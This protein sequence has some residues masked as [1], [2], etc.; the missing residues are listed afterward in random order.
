MERIVHTWPA[1]LEPLIAALARRPDRPDCWFSDVDVSEDEL[2]ALN[3][4]EA[5]SRHG[6]VCF[7]LPGAEHLAQG[8]MNTLLGLGAPVERS[9]SARVRL[10]FHDVASEK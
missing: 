5:S 9:R 6:R 3:L 4:F 8:E 7:K 1:A 2:K 10:S